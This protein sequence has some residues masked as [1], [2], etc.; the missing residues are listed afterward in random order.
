MRAWPQIA[1]QEQSDYEFLQK[2][3]EN[4][5]AYTCSFDIDALPKPF[6]KPALIITG[7]QDSSVGY[8]DAWL[9]SQ[10]YPR[11]T[12]VVF[13]RAGHFLEEKEPLMGPLFN[14]WL[15]RIEEATPTT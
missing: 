15:D 10:N 14:E 4:P 1:E 12:Y 8:K 11:A 13:D 7:R 5:D 3:R 9:L 6:T 2:I